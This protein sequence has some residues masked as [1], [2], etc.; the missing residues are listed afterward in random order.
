MITNMSIEELFVRLLSMPT[1]NALHARQT[2]HFAISLLAR[3]CLR[4]TV[5][6]YH[7]KFHYNMRQP[8]SF[9]APWLTQEPPWAGIFR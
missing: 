9:G 8:K 3:R 2:F 5:S 7:F 4:Q 6:A 1:H